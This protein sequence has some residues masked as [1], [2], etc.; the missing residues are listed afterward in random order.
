MATGAQQILPGPRG[1]HIN[2]TKPIA[3]TFASKALCGGTTKGSRGPINFK[4]SV[5]NLEMHIIVS[6]LLPIRV[7][8][9]RNGF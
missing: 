4:V 8:G 9:T 3:R 7:N 5:N 2:H 1:G 6:K